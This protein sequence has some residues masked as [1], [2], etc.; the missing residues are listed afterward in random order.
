MNMPVGCS[1]GLCVAL[2]Y[3]T[4]LV[5]TC[6]FLLLYNEIHF[7]KLNSLTNKNKTNK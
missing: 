5:T 7:N 4:I 1:M 3:Y 6:F 2:N